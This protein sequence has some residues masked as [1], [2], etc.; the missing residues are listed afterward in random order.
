MIAETAQHTMLPPLREWPPMFG[1]TSPRL[2]PSNDV[3]AVQSS[4]DEFFAMEVRNA[5]GGDCVMPS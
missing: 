2:V 5:R 4:I 3:A 1:W